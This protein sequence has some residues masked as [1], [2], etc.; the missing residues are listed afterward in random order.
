MA[1]RV[2]GKFSATEGIQIGVQ[3]IQVLLTT[4]SLPPE[5]ILSLFNCFL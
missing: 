5:E 4:D 1:L 3:R 2:C